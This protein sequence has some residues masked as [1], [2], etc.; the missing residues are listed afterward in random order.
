MVSSNN[1]CHFFQQS[2]WFVVISSHKWGKI[3]MN[4]FML[5]NMLDDFDYSLSFVINYSSIYLLLCFNVNTLAFLC[6]LK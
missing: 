4:I 1:Y 5:R 6:F 3:E 2:L